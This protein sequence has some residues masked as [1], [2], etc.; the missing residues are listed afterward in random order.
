MGG[1]SGGGGGGYGRWGGD[2]G[3]W[4]GGDFQDKVKRWDP[5]LSWDWGW[6]WEGG[7]VPYSETHWFA[8]CTLI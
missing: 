8:Y 6:D 2:G 7:G 3:V 4:K 5:Q 1:W